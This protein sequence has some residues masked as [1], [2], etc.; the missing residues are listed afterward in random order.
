MEKHVK[1]DHSKGPDSQFSI[2]YSELT[3]LVNH[4]KRI[5]KIQNIGTNKKSMINTEF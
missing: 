3:D 1:L 4:S 2:H 5:D